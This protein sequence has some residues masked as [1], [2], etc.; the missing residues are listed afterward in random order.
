MT[1]IKGGNKIRELYK[2]LRKKHGQPAGQWRLWCKR[3]KKLCERE[4]VIIG[5]IL[6]QNTNWRN[7][8]KAMEELKKQGRCS[9]VGIRQ[10]GRN[11]ARLGQMIRAAGFYNTK[12]KYLL[13]IA[14]FFEEIGGVKKAMRMDMADLRKMLLAQKGVGPETADSILNYALDMP[15]FVIDE[16]T[17]RIVRKEKISRSREYGFLKKLF[18]KNIKKDFAGYQDVHA[19]IV[20]AN[21]TK[22][23]DRTNKT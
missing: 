13:E 16:Y 3:P 6:T 14:K 23:K 22:G 11:R 17:R 21:K 19:L 15:S 9:L 4:E 1:N 12:S 5:S 10:M 18:E 2:R 8:A 20:I 7:V